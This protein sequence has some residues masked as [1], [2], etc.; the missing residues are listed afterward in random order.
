MASTP[1]NQQTHWFSADRPIPN[2]A[3]D[4]LSRSHFAEALA[5]AVEGWSGK[6]SLVIALYAQWG[7]GKTSIKNMVVDAIHS[8]NPPGVEIAEF[9]PWE[10]ANREQ[11]TELFF[12][13]LSI[14]LGKGSVATGE[15]R[16]R[17]VSRLRRYATRLKAGADLA[18]LFVK[19][20]TWLVLAVGV[21]AIAIPLT[22]RA[23]ATTLG[24]ILVAAATGLGFAG[25][26]ATS[27]AEFLGA[28]VEGNRKSLREMKDELI[29]DL[30]QLRRPLLVIVDDADRLTPQELQQLFQ[31]VKVNADFP[32]VIYL[33]ILDRDVAAN[34]LNKA[35][36]V[37]GYDY[38][39]K[40][41]QVPFNIPAL[42]RPRLNKILLNKLEILLADCP[43]SVKFDES[44]WAN[45]FVSCL[46]RFFDNLRD[47]NRFLSTFAFHL[48]VF[49]TGNSL[50]VNPI[51]LIALEVIRV[52]EPKTYKAIA[53][54]KEL[55]TSAKML[56][57]GEPKERADAEQMIINQASDH[58]KE[59]ISEL[60]SHMF[61]LF[62]ST[63]G[64]SAHLP[65]DRWQRELRACAE[66]MFDR[67]F[68]FSI[69]E[70]DISQ[71]RIDAL[72][73]ASGDRTKLRDQLLSL[74][75]ENL[76]DIAID[77]LDAYKEEIPAEHALP[78]VT[79]LFDIGDYLTE[80]FPTQGFFELSPAMHGSRIIR[81][82][83]KSLH[84]P[85]KRAAV[86][87]EAI[88]DTSGLSL[89]VHFIMIQQQAA[90]KNDPTEEVFI[91]ASAL[92]ELQELCVSKIKGAASTGE[93][94]H[95]P[96]LM[97]ILFRWRNWGGAE[98]AKNWC[99]ILL[100]QTD[101]ALILLRAFTRRSV[102]L[103]SG[104]YLEKVSWFI[105]LSD[106]ELFVSL[107][108]INLFIE[109]VSVDALPPEGARAVNAYREAVE[110]R[111]KGK[112]DFGDELFE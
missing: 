14:A 64:T 87:K 33:L 63:T 102:K 76:L 42:N 22:G 111:A 40:I 104:D 38:L 74:N 17:L 110:R 45:L 12:D 71:S 97:N 73:A 23:V 29:G 53:A 20:V 10:V 39:D 72:I 79:A 1:A 100:Q 86:L 81:W 98:D 3:A 106:F 37:N 11:L 109:K 43:Q 44:R 66:E 60:L 82:Y 101:G 59:T 80:N 90:A 62:G 18:S 52:F 70:G 5:K 30:A 2:R 8:K 105:R 89:V 19:A 75:S 32:N 9:N 41:V 56:S 13:E 50:E 46:Q 21:V 55:L 92:T 4:L 54:N 24:I 84:E 16:R 61:P 65:T 58:H 47:V 93:L 34:H 91:T 78:F 83:L 6:D 51:D 31:L 49:R 77:R 7:M 25:K 28:T 68:H 99:N 15:M 36:S 103:S 95:S 88:E 69:L 107:E 85:E 26:V 67:Y 96:S 35:L 27:L 94:A 108:K 57:F 112:K 48:S